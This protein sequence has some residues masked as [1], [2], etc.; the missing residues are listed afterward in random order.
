MRGNNHFNP[1]L[2]PL[3]ENLGKYSIVD[4]MVGRLGNGWFLARCCRTEGL[5]TECSSATPVVGLMNVVRRQA[6]VK[7][8][9]NFSSC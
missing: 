5:V 1:S 2:F 4:V 7:P 8:P 6:G 3:T 9:F